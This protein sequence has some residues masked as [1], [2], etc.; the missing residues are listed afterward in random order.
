MM[1]KKI[2]KI[3]KVSQE[4]KVLFYRKDCFNFHF[5]YKVVQSTK[6]EKVTENCYSECKNEIF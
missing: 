3:I 1:K 5:F 4:N 2:Q 6:M